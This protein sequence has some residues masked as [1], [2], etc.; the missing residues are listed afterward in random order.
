MNRLRSRI[1]SSPLSER[2]PWKTGVAASLQLLPPGNGPR[3]SLHIGDAAHAIA[4][5]VG[6]VEAQRRAPVVHHEHDRLRATDDGIDEGPEIFSVRRRSGSV[7]GP[8][9]AV[10]RNRP[11]RSGRGRSAGRMPFEL[12]NA[13]RARDRTRSGCRAAT[14]PQ[15]PRRARGK[16]CG[17]RAH[18]RSFSS[19]S[20][21]SL[22][23][24][25]FRFQPTLPRG[26]AGTQTNVA[27]L[28][29]FRP[30]RGAGLDNL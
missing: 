28:H 2:K 12:G 10:W 22:A 6:P 15:R 1:I 26:R 5:M 11:C 4:V 19:A 14:G 3:R 7:S 21:L 16:P 20:V 30:P 18:R 9:W 27:R 24:C 29:H 13:R 25:L 17:R 8:D 23:G